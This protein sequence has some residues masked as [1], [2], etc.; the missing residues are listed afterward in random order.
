MSLV[1]EGLRPFLRRK[2]VSMTNANVTGKTLK[3]AIRSE[4]RKS[5]QTHV[6]MERMPKAL[7]ERLRP[8]LYPPFED[9]EYLT[10][11]AI[12]HGYART[13]LPRIEP[14]SIGLSIWSPPYFVGKS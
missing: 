13:L 1:A 6:T 10:P 3:E 5:S 12:Y 11:N 2:R 7:Q 8:V 4:R 9:V 14:N